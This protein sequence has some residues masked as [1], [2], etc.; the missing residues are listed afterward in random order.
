MS[1]LR[2]RVVRDRGLDRGGTA[3]ALGG[4]GV[5]VAAVI[6]FVALMALLFGIEEEDIILLFGINATI[7]VG[8]Q[9]F[10][11]NTGIMS[12]GHVAFVGLGAY[13]VGV[14]SVP[15]ATRAAFLPDLPGFLSNLA[16]SPVPAILFAGLVAGI[17]GLLF[18]PFV[19]RLPESTATIITFAMLVVVYD[20]LG[21]ADSIT[22]GTKTFLGVPNKSS[23][24]LVFATL[25]LVVLASAAFKWSRLGLRARAARDD[26]AAAEASGISVGTSRLW[27]FVLSAVITGIGGGLWA[28]QVTAFTPN[29]FYIAQVI[30]FVAMMILGGLGSVSGAL[31]GATVMSLWL[32]LIRHVENG[33]VSLASLHIPAVQDL[34]QLTLGILL[35]LLL[36]W[37]SSGLAGSRE[38][39]LT[40][41]RPGRRRGSSAAEPEPTGVEPGG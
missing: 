29:S 17:C 39:Q 27:P 41:S 9:L 11:G 26:P 33:G 25:A 16:L 14:V 7:V 2:L 32:E 24:V 15:L 1:G 22:R 34:S 28:Y 3:G 30:P 18:G 38:L 13:A 12:F 37:R 8:L 31:L 6:A 21:N 40:F 5:A 35:V 19:V 4:A 10:V 36:R 20:V 23:Y